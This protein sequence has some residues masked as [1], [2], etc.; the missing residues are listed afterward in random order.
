MSRMRHA[1]FPP[2]Y[3]KV[4]NETLNTDGGWV[5]ECLQGL[6]NRQS[7]EKIAE[8]FSQISQ[9]YSPSIK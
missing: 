1:P 6:D 3:R 9:E 4:E 7:A 2:P 5:V 8:F